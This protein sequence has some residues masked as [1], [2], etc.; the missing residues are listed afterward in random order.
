M[1]SSRRVPAPLAL[2][3]AGAV[4]CG[5]VW[6]AACAA[7]P[8]RLQTASSGPA[9]AGGAAIDPV[10]AAAT[11]DTAWSL[12]DRNH[13]D[14][15]HGG[16]DWPAVRQELRPR[17]L[18]TTHRD[19][20]RALLNEMIGRTG[21]SHFGLLPREAVDVLR[22]SKETETLDAPAGATDDD[23]EASVG[24]DVRLV[25]GE[26][27]VWRI[28][29]RS[30]AAGAGIAPGWVLAAVDTTSFATVLERIGDGVE[31]GVLALRLVMLAR[32]LLDGPLGS[33]VR[34]ALR[35]AADQE[36][37]L[38][39]TRARQPGVTNQLGN[40]PPIRTR[41]EHELIAHAGLRVG[42]IGFN[43]WLLPIA[44]EFDAAI[45]EYRDADA[46][47]I[48]LR[49]NLGGVG[50]MTMGL[51]GHLLDEPVSL[52]EMRTRQSALQFRVNPRRTNPAGERVRPFA[53]PVAILQD[54]LSVSTSEIFAQGLQ[55]LGRA[56]VFGET[57]AG[58]ALPS[59]LERLPNGDVLQ[60]AFADFVDPAGTR[61]EGRGVIPDEVV[62]LRR[63]DLLAGRDAPLAAALS[64]CARV[65]AESLVR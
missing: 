46:L 65:L 19:S 47:I 63:E 50:G 42:R 12:I 5:A 9:V 29:P 39:L 2:L 38:S 54:R 10:L 25:G 40:L 23:H 20:L 30:P 21:L 13:F 7:S 36:Q 32:S 28:E 11:F 26:L 52:G 51:A 56:R 35:D 31:A 49:G 8:A 48:D 16:V 64:W 17:A 24:L 41:L 57:S 59:R 6:L 18:T 55:V 3:A 62:P 58:A 61:L 1:T 33:E 27:L 14:P 60:F 44:A 22:T 45:E 4:Y 34:L 37:D 43:I 15:A 53:G